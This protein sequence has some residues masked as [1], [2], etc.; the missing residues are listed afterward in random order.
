LKSQ[1][2]F[3]DVV[4]STQDRARELLSQHLDLNAVWVR[5]AQQ[6]KG[7]GRQGRSWQNGPA[8][9]ESFLCSVALQRVQF[10]FGLELVPLAA[11]WAIYKS[12]GARSS[13]Q[14]VLGVK[15]PNDIVAY[16]GKN[17]HK[18]LGGILCESRGQ[19]PVVTV[20]WGLN[21]A[22]QNLPSLD[23]ASS[24]FEEFNEV[25]EPADLQKRLEQEF[26]ALQSLPAR[27][28]TTLLSTGPMQ[29]LWG[30]TGTLASGET[31]R[32]VGLGD[33]GQ[34]IVEVGQQSRQLNSGEFLMTYTK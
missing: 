4:D 22:G 24:V 21:L 29:P 6:T 30:A 13:G 12:V 20:G 32:A 2:F 19:N 17:L 27:D 28:L 3:F 31:G 1:S 8:P 18:K 15:W 11:A 14:T 10:K 7:R 23:H 5:A 16:K 33:G 9:N 34:L 26:F 25:I